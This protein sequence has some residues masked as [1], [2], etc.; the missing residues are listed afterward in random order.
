MKKLYNII[1][2]V[3]LASAL[4]ASAQSDGGEVIA[5]V[6]TYSA[7]Q[8]GVPL[9]FHHNHIVYENIGQSSVIAPNVF[10]AKV[11]WGTD[12]Q[13]KGPLVIPTHVRIGIYTFDV[14]RLSSAAFQQTEVTSVVIKAGVHSI[15]QNCFNFCD[16]LETVRLESS[17]IHFIDNAAFNGCIKLR[18]I[19]LPA[20]MKRIGDYA[21]RECLKLEEIIIPKNVVEIGPYAFNRC[22]S[23]R[24][25]TFHTGHFR[26]IPEY[27][28]QTCESLRDVKIPEGVSTLGEC[29]FNQSGLRSITLPSTLRRIE[30]NALS[31]TPITDIYCHAM[32]PPWVAPNFT[33]EQCAVIRVHVPAA[34]VEAYRTDSFWH[35]FPNI[36]TIE[37]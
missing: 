16:K 9:S 11:I 34:A 3:A 23:L 12:H 8:N 29:S 19:N 2:A 35:N 21:F 28:F 5:G 27:C 13:F 4:T 31:E 22:K 33:Y 6:Y 20:G 36:M 15:P 26:T 25:L 30:S 14:D 24:S 17:D 18:S 37:D 10:K 7:V 1:A 32:T